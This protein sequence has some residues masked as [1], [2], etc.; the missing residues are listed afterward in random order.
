MTPEALDG[1]V[2]SI[3]ENGDRIRFDVNNGSVELLVDKELLAKRLTCKPDLSAN[4]HGFGRELF[5]SIRNSISS[6][7]EGACVFDIPGGE[8]A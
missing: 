4:R 6:A 3:I 1:G 5:V 2:L 7:E 8:R